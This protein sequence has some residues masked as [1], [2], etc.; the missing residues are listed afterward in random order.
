MR[1]IRCIRSGGDGATGPTSAL[2]A[3][4]SKW[5]RTVPGG[6][7]VSNLYDLWAALPHGSHAQIFFPRGELLNS[8]LGIKQFKAA[9]TLNHFKGLVRAAAALTVRLSEISCICFPLERPGVVKSLG[10]ADR[11]RWA[12][13]HILPRNWQ[14]LFFAPRV[15]IKRRHRFRSSVCAPTTRLSLC[16]KT[17]KFRGGGSHGSAD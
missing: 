9:P 3:N 16:K 10:S 15:R 11:D 7:G 17:A 2:A 8:L 5:W 4:L 12:A 6:G 14:N 1:H 13:P